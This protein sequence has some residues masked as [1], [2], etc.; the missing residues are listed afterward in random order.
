M[1]ERTNGR[2]GISQ[3]RAPPPRPFAAVSILERGFP[4]TIPR[5]TRRK[6]ESALPLE[7]LRKGQTS[8]S[9]MRIHSTQQ[10]PGTPTQ[11]HFRS[12]NL[13][14][15]MPLKKMK[16]HV[17]EVSWSHRPPCSRVPRFPT[18]AWVRTLPPT[19]L[20]RE[21][22]SKTRLKWSISLK[23]LRMAWRVL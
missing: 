22:P 1:N 11:N 13:S 14:A 18:M 9:K 7:N 16:L 6:R 21:F 10:P 17:L 15:P 8:W 12:S 3:H 4:T 19:A 23:L 2:T 5:V 20:L